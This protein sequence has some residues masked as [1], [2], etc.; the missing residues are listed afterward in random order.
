[1]NRKQLIV[2]GIVALVLCGIG[3]LLSR[4][5]ANS[6][7]QARRGPDT[8]LLGEFPVNDVAQVA[9]RE[10]TNQVTLVQG[11]TW[12]VRER[13]DYPANS[14]QVI[15]FVR[16]LWDLRAA[17]SQ[18]V[19]ESQLGRL[20][21]EDPEKGGTNSAMLVEL[22]DKEG[23]VLR[24][25]RLGKESMRGGDTGD[26]FGG[27]GWPNGRWIYLPD[28]PGT[29]YLVSE[30]FMSIEAQPERWL[31]KDFVRVEKARSIQ[32]D[33][34]VE[35]NSWKLT[36]ESETGTWQLADAKEGEELDTTKSASVTTAFNWP[37]FNDVLPGD[38]LG[39]T[40]EATVRLET[41]DNFTYTVQIGGKTNNDYLVQVAVAAQLARERTPGADEKPEDKERL[42]KEFETQ[43]EKL[44]EKL[45]KESAFGKWTYIVPSYVVDPL[46]KPRS[47]LLAEKK[48]E[49]EPAEEGSAETTD[50][51]TDSVSTAATADGPVFDPGLPSSDF[52]D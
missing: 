1:M 52:G 41:F 40:N 15:E 20:Q 33:F 43:R 21:L 4:N 5:R 16:K 24:S 44:E 18:K 14:Q 37:S 34:P 27:G 48:E 31:N 51:G 10:G 9:L 11:E 30:T 35:T 26:P 32:V 42:D 8:R 50:A 25:V 6:Y 45:K 39:E 47:E 19:G 46:L 38:A 12:T 23:K 17:Q 29:A 22:K 3:V 36:R 49:P 28:Q 2:I 13:H 7:E